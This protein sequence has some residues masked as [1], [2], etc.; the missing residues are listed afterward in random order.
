MTLVADSNLTERRAE[1]GGVTGNEGLVC[2][3]ESFRIG[4]KLL[5]RSRR[6]LYLV[7]LQVLVFLSHG[8]SSLQWLGA[9]EVM[10]DRDQANPVI[11]SNR[12]RKH[13]Y[14]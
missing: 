9:C 2:L 1:P 7:V 3:A 14:R 6:L 11:H 12:A 13:P 4:R 5:N 8:F 10:P